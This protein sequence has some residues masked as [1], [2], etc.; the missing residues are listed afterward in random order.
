M[1][2]TIGLTTK[3]APAATAQPLR[4]T[5][6]EKQGQ[7]SPNTTKITA[8]CA[9]KI[10]PIIHAMITAKAPLIICKIN[11]PKTSLV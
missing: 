9:A 3:R 10:P 7:H 5:R 8:K 6:M 11:A 4:A 1:I 2:I